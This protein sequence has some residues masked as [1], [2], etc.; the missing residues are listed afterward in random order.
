MSIRDEVIALIDQQQIL[1]VP[2]TDS[3][4]IYQ[5]LHMDSMAFILLILDLEEKY[6][7]TVTLQEM[8]RCLV[9]GELIALVENKA[10]SRP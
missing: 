3:T 10:G 8:E 2:I 6:N 5:D 7:M 1:S 9:V 4:H